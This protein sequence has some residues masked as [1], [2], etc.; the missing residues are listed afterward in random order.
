MPV[1]PLVQIHLFRIFVCPVARSGLCA[2]TLRDNHL[3]PLSSFH[4][5]VIRGFLHLSD[6]SP[7]PALF[8]LTGEL[9]IVARLH[10]DIFSLFYNIWINPGTKIF[11]ITKYC[12]LNS[13]P[14]EKFI[15][16]VRYGRP[17]NTNLSTTTIKI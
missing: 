3:N 9:P 8:F 11:K 12:P 17:C 15:R 5:K 7:I 14:R 13:Q 1:S 4:R 16:H 10:R 2:M 6:R